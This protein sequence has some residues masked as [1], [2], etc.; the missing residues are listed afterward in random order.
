MHVCTTDHE[1]SH[2]NP[3][4]I[5]HLISIT[6]QLIETVVFPITKQS[7]ETAVFFKYII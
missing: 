7:I 4:K 6:K 5:I 3:L 1:L 2:N